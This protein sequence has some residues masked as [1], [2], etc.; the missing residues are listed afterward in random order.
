MRWSRPLSR[1]GKRSHRYYHAAGVPT[2]H[3][4][5]GIHLLARLLR[6]ETVMTSSSEPK[7]RRFNWERVASMTVPRSQQQQSL[8]AGDDACS[9]QAFLPLG[10]WCPLKG[11]WDVPPNFDYTRST[12]NNYAAPAEHSKCSYGIYKDVRATRDFEYHGTYTRGRQLF[13]GDLV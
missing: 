1:R 6:T 3:H 8:V 11:V 13:Q 10:G 9:H 7:P 2:S 4:S 12:A 5:H